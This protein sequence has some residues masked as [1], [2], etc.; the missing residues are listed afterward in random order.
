MRAAAAAGR[1]VFGYNRSVEGAHGAL[2]LAEII[3][4]SG[5]APGV[6]NLVMG[7]G[8]VVGQ[9]LI[10][11][12][13]VAAV[14]FTGSVSTGRTSWRLTWARRHASSPRRII[15]ESSRAW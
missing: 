5:I 12:P 8:S 7:S 13:D 9:T 15:P 4:R 11:H 3:A 10:E 2:A 14:S 6:F 1:E